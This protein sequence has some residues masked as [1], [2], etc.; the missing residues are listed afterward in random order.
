MPNRWIVGIDPDQEEQGY[1][2]HRQAPE[3]LAKWGVEPEGEAILS[4]LVYTDAAEPDSIAIYDFEWDD[5]MPSDEVF[6]KVCAEGIRCIDRYLDFTA[7]L[8]E[9]MLDIEAEEQ[10]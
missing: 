7:G 4:G 3:F 10:E 6:R 5:D 2:I 8:K 1:I 9:E